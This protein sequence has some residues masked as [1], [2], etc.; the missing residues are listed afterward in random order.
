MLGLPGVPYGSPFTRYFWKGAVPILEQEVERFA[1]ETGQRPMLVGTATWSITA[2]LTY[3]GPPAWEDDVGLRHFFGNTASMREAW[4]DPNDATGRPIVLVSRRR[5]KLERKSVV[6]RLE[7]LGPIQERTIERDGIA[8]RPLYFRTAQR[9][10][11][12]PAQRAHES[13]PR[14]R[15]S[16]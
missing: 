13:K 12:P 11:G 14:V 16:R 2:M 9:Y 7:G 6:D 1:A 8:L 4:E 5:T 15:P 10:R 3:Y